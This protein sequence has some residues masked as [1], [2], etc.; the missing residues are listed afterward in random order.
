MIRDASSV[1]ADLRT[2]RAA[3]PGMPVLHLFHE[4]KQM[5]C[6]GSLNLLH[7]YL[8]S[9]HQGECHELL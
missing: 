2:R 9:I 8:A 6:T 4:I 1:A 3:E 5:G 7:R